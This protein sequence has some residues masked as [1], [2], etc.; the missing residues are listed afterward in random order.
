MVMNAGEG[1]ND[2]C[3]RWQFYVAIYVANDVAIYVANDVKEGGNAGPN[4]TYLYGT[5]SR[6]LFPMAEPLIVIITIEGIR[7]CA[8][9]HDTGTINKFDCIG[10]G[11]EY[12]IHLCTVFMALRAADCCIRYADMLSAPIFTGYQTPFDCSGRHLV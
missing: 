11:H 5:Q 4:S 1:G 6:L 3:R 2:A 9:T 7:I 8:C 12:W 10:Q